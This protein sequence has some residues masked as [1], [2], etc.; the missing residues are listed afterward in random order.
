MSK[1]TLG[2]PLPDSPFFGHYADLRLPVIDQSYVLTDPST[3]VRTGRTLEEI[4]TRDDAGALGTMLYFGHPATVRALGKSYTGVILPTHGHDGQVAS[5]PENDFFLGFENHKFRTPVSQTLLTEYTNNPGGIVIGESLEIKD[6]QTGTR[7]K[8]LFGS[9]LPEW[10]GK[11]RTFAITLDGG[12]QRSYEIIGD[13]S[14]IVTPRTQDFTVQELMTRVMKFHGANFLWGASSTQFSDASGW[15]QNLYSSFGVHLPHNTKRMDAHLRQG[16]VPGTEILNF[17]DL[18]TGDLVFLGPKNKAI[19]F[20]GMVELD[21]NGDYWLRHCAGK[22][23]MQSDSI[24]DS[25]GAIRRSMLLNE[26]KIASAPSS[27]IKAAWR[28]FDFA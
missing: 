2:S 18:K 3:P 14:N 10:D 19:G 28:L 12:G 6:L 7:H 8:I 20:M 24:T 13:L 1:S 22:G 23:G 27:E 15:I 17:R 5:T 16:V 9:R 26:G 11:S 4:V 25:S 21:G